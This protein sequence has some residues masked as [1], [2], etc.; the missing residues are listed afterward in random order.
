MLRCRVVACL[1]LF[2]L[3]LVWV[4]LPLPFCALLQPFLPPPLS[5]PA[6]LL[7]DALRPAFCG[8]L[9][10]QYQPCPVLRPAIAGSG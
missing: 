2:L 9:P 4:V 1:C 3:S 7:L 6:L 5:V 8:S 10:L